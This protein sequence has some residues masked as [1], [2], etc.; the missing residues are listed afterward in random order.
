MIVVLDS[1]CSLKEKA[2]VVRFIER[3]GGRLLVSEIG[4]ET[5]IGLID[6]EAQSL[7]GEIESMPGVAELR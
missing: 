7:A 4:D 5:H 3:R 2:G 1:D 6:T